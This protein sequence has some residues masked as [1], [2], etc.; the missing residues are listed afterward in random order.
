M[1]KKDSKFYIHDYIR[2]WNA[3]ASCA[4]VFD[5]AEFP[6]YTTDAHGW[7]TYFNEAA[8]KL[9][10]LRPVLGEARWCGAWRLYSIDRSLLPHSL[11][12]MAVAL[13]EERAVRGA[14]AVLEKPDGAHVPFVPYPTPVWDQAG[15]IVA[16]FNL[17]RP[18]DAQCRS[19]AA[20]T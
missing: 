3:E 20:R 1:S 16:G 15:K 7:L 17:L 11:C 9:W 5:A 19:N 18:V 6:L 2:D 10:G 4:D 12:P 14:L 13:K 8:A